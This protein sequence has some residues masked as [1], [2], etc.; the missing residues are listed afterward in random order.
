MN[1]RALR[2]LKKIL[3]KINALQE[4]MRQLSDD[5]LRDLTNVFKQEIKDGAS[6]DDLLVQSYAVAREA[7]KRVLNMYPYDE[8]VLAAIAL[9]QGRIVEMKTGEGKTLVA[10]MPLY[11]NALTGKSAI[12]VTSNDYLARRDGLEMGKLYHFLGLTVGIGVP[13][14]PSVQFKADEKRAIYKSDIVYTTHGVLA[15]DYLL[16][17]LVTSKE[18]RYLRHFSYIVIDE[19]DSVL[20]DAATMPLVSSG[21]P[22]V[23]SN[24]YESAD[25]FVGTLKED[26]DYKI[27]DQE[28]FLTEQGIDAAERFFG[29]KNLYS[30]QYFD[31]VRHIVLA[32]RA[33]TLFKKDR[34]YV[35]GDHKVSLLDHR[36]GRI[37]ENTKLKSGLHQAIEA[38]EHCKLTEDSRAMASITYQSFFRLFDKMSGMSGA[39]YNERKELKKV[40]NLDTIIIPTHKKTIRIDAP[41]LYFGN[42]EEQA[43]AAKAFILKRHAT[44]QPLLIVTD[45]IDSSYEYSEFLLAHGIAHNV[46]NAYNVAKEA[47]IIK[48]A[49]QKNAVT[50]AT[51]VAGRGTDIRL[52][53]GVRELGG[54]CVVGI[55]RQYN[56]RSEKQTR[57]RSGRQG[58]PGYSQFFISIDD[59]VVDEYGSTKLTKHLNDH[60]IKSR[61]VIRMINQAQINSETMERKNRQETMEYDR[62]V[63]V[64]RTLIYEMRNRII[65]AP[66][67]TVKDVYPML[68]EKID[69]F[70]NKKQGDVKRF[71]LDYL[72]YHFDGKLLDI[73]DPKQLREALIKL[74]HHVLDEKKQITQDE[75]NGYIKNT[76]L[77]AIDR[78]WVEQVD[79]LEQLRY[80]IA[81][82]QYSQRNIIYMFH[83]EAYEA[84]DV[85][86]KKIKDQ[87]IKNVMLSMVINNSNENFSILLP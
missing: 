59:R 29:V 60:Q 30:G 45:S 67:I 25:Y 2:K 10:T 16:E 61:H 64:Q 39:V 69:E 41:D 36:S 28:V 20:L 24:L 82:R 11:L 3:T 13:E 52:G 4:D 46:L 6:V 55:G 5:E 27:E 51:S 66:T 58:D 81:L 26:E 9:H 87:A 23:Q 54:L 32:L 73:K 42:K 62:S 71:V 43:S 1:A 8:Q 77:N 31:I 85:M 35:V 12:L 17:N 19:V 38:K 63:S 76:L 40:Y 48:D 70:L 84:F 21:A 72:T 80:A 14:D 33:H 7:A 57:G 74:A 83:I 68:D 56:L 15:F 65:D 75:F 44:G 86:L 47:E 34:D 18:E 37:F 79:Y 50:V 53:K 22:R 49:G 78:E